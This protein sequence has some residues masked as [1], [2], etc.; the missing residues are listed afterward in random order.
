MSLF[1]YVNCLASGIL[2]KM[3][4]RKEWEKIKRVIVTYRLGRCCRRPWVLPAAAVFFL[5]LGTSSLVPFCDY[6]GR[7]LVAMKRKGRKGWRGLESYRG[8]PDYKRLAEA[9]PS[10]ATFCLSKSIRW[11]G[12][13]WGVVQLYNLLRLQFVKCRFTRKMQLW[14]MPFAREATAFGKWRW[15]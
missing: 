2:F 10:E 13:W 1:S 15:Q 11:V 5:G 8:S 7:V 4:T 6:G 12:S 9:F 14:F 3:Q